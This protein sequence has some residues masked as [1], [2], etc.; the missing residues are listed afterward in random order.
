MIP[1]LLQ[2]FHDPLGSIG[3]DLEGVLTGGSHVW[4][5]PVCELIIFWHSLLLEDLGVFY[6]GL[7]TVS[8]MVLRADL[9]NSVW[10]ER[11]VLLE[12]LDDL[13]SPFE[14]SVLAARV[15]V[16]LAVNFPHRR[17]V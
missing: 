11:A 6:V 15:R 13:A 1:L 2:R 16:G 5:L 17:C 4:F 10:R 3:I 14:G 8:R 7:S 9:G 12:L